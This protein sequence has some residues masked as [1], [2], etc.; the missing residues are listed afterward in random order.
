MTAPTIHG[1]S[2][3]RAELVTA[4][5]SPQHHHAWL[6]HG[7]MGIGKSLLA[8]EMAQAFL[9]QGKAARPC[10][11]CHSCTIMAA[12]GHPDALL[13][14][15]EE[16]KRDI[17]VAQVRQLLDFL[18][19]TGYESNRRV[20]VIDDAERL[21]NAAANALLKG[22]EEPA[23]GCLIIMVC[24]DLQRL[25]ATILSRCMLQACNALDEGTT[26]T[27][28]QQIG[29]AESTLN[30]ATALAQGQP[31]R[32][33]CLL[34]EHWSSHLQQWQQ[35]TENIS[36]LDIGQAQK[37]VAGKWSPQPLALAVAMVLEQVRLQLKQY[38]FTV[39]EQALS[40]C[41]QLAEV[42]TRVEQQSI[43]C[44]QALLGPMIELRRIF[45]MK[46]DD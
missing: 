8:H 3:L 5:T 2:A 13:L 1:H 16:G 28:L 37:L 30:M 26:R 39:V 40:A 24:S 23:Q 20:V 32:S 17:P 6:L 33:A 36:Q 10:Q 25:P 44:D 35:L 18:S 27:V 46:I 15:R 31:G 43:R 7:P 9:C 42:P 11:L 34:D 4:I 29:I 38:P 19:L 12:D 41:Q 22:L 21:N 14:Q 45:S